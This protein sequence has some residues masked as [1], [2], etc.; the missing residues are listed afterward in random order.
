MAA[1]GGSAVR[2]TAT[3]SV[4]SIERAMSRRSS[5]SS[6]SHC[7]SDRHHVAAR[8]RCRTRS[9]SPSR[10]P[11]S[12]RRAARGTR[13]SAARCRRAAPVAGR[14]QGSRATWRW[15]EPIRGLSGRVI[16]HNMTIVIRRSRLGSD[17]RRW[18]HVGAIWRSSSHSP[19]SSAS[20]SSPFPASV[21]AGTAGFVRT[22]A[23]SGRLH[24]PRA[25]AGAPPTGRR[26]RARVRSRGTRTAAVA[27][28]AGTGV[29]YASDADLDW[30]D[31]LGWGG[32]T[33]VV[34]DE[35]VWEE[36]PATNGN[37]AGHGGAAGHA[38][39]P[40]T[41]PSGT[42]PHGRSRPRR[43]TRPPRSRPTAPRPPTAHAA[44]SAT[45]AA[46]TSAA[47]ASDLTAPGRRR[48]LRARRGR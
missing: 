35:P 31:D 1:S 27:T 15:G 38:G 4:S 23:S 17:P 47:A 34:K 43:P 12:W 41:S 28:G 45:L 14:R 48:D 19:P 20:A 29:T 40:R 42:S 33:A 11:C 5:T 13:R 3:R 9:A 26:Q 18:H 36:P 6:S 46:P 2:C 24:T 21:V 30:D 32:D 44:P 37:G 39:R 16:G 7:G 10:R 25:A 8:P 22:R